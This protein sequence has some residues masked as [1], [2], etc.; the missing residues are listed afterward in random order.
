MKRLDCWNGDNGEVV[1][2]HGRTLT[3]KI[4]FEDVIKCIND[5]GF[6]TSPYPVILSLD[7]HADIPGQEKM[8]EIMIRVFGDRLLMPDDKMVQWPSPNELKGK[9]I[10]KNKK[11]PATQQVQEDIIDSDSDSDDED[12]AVDLSEKEEKP[13]KEKHPKVKVAQKLSD[14]TALGTTKLTNFEDEKMFK[15]P[16]NKMFS[17]S[18]GRVEKLFQNDC[19]NLIKFG[20]NH[21]SRS[22]PHGLRFDSSNYDPVP[23]FITGVQM[24]ALNTQTH[25]A[26]F[27]M[28]EFK[29]RENAM[30]GYLL[31][32]EML[33]IMGEPYPDEN[34]PVK[35]RLSK[36]F[37]I[38]LFT[39]YRI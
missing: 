14:I 12:F 22:Y 16:C 17:I 8:A 39:L 24:S 25:C 26:F 10:L 35:Q 1:I 33:R 30:S 15:L 28:N 27:R 36:F 5:Y 23:S 9:V 19:A 31:K 29:F 34:T 21:F 20:Y 3:S 37:S 38:Y 13:K 2:Y 18:E 7:V 11:V 32:P 6:K 4:L